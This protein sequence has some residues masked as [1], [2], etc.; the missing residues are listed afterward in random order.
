MIVD[1]SFIVC[2]YMCAHYEVY[3]VHRT[4]ALCIPHFMAI[5]CILYGYNIFY[6]FNVFCVLHIIYCILCA[7]LYMY[8]LY[9]TLR[10]VTQHIVLFVGRGAYCGTPSVC[11]TIIAVIDIIYCVVLTIY[12]IR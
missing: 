10:R 9:S 5:L 3:G 7:I 11:Y 2:Q 8:I 4:L 6:T 12:L 1:L